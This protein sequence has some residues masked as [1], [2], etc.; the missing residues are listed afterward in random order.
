MVLVSMWNMFAGTEIRAILVSALVAP[1]E[2][3]IKKRVIYAVHSIFFQIV[4]V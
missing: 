2:K 4:L 3:Q 1:E